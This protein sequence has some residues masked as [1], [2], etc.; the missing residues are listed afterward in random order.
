MR[1]FGTK[2]LNEECDS[3]IFPNNF[4]DSLISELSLDQGLT[5]SKNALI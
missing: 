4:N 2:R 3:L 5:Q 1:P